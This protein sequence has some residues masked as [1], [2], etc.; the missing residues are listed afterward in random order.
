MW[1]IINIVCTSPLL[2]VKYAHN[3]RL[4]HQSC[5]QG[6]LSWAVGPYL[7]LFTTNLTRWLH[8]HRLGC[9]LAPRSDGSQ[10][11]CSE[12]GHPRGWETAFMCMCGHIWSVPDNNGRLSIPSDQT[13]DERENEP[14]CVLKALVSWCISSLVTVFRLVNADAQSDAFK[15]NITLFTRILDSL[16]DGYDNRLRPGLG[17]KETINDD[18]IKSA[19]L[20]NVS[21]L[22][23]YFLLSVF[24]LLFVMILCAFK[25]L[26]PCFGWAHLN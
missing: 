17:G 26:K 8:L 24:A 25:W 18:W 1:K 12:L 5:Q 4:L 3:L 23:V 16:L 21:A 19:S 22:P 7:N 9:V 13:S 20:F 11:L 10:M 15:T 6:W 2:E 14:K